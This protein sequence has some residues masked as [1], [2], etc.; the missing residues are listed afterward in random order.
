[1]EK[2]TTRI[3][4]FG[5]PFGAQEENHIIFLVKTMKYYPISWAE[6]LRRNHK[7]PVTPPFAG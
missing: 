1:M 7:V 3:H 4:G 5:I 2:D 6:D